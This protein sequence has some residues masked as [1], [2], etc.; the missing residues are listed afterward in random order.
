MG[1][2]YNAAVSRL[3]TNSQCCDVAA[4]AIDR[5]A[6]NR[7]IDSITVNQSMHCHGAWWLSDVNMDWTCKKDK[8]KDKD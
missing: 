8:D 6:V 3:T 7:L 4:A 2:A 5:D 1:G